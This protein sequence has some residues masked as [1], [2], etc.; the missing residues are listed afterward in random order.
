MRAAVA[1]ASWT[2][3][4]T[5]VVSASSVRRSR[6]NG[7]VSKS[8]WSATPAA[9]AGWA[10]CMSRARP[11]PSPRTPS[12]LTR[13]V[14]ESSANRPVVTVRGYDVSAGGGRDPLV[15]RRA[16]LQRPAERLDDGAERLLVHALAVRGAGGA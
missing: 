13:R 8:L 7:S 4:N 11:P 3:P 2:V 5:S 15:E 14:I 16:L 1:C 12:L 10:S 6:P 9:T